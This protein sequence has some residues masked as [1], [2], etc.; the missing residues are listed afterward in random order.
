MSRRWSVAGVAW[1]IAVVG[2]VLQGIVGSWLAAVLWLVVMGG[3]GALFSPLAFPRAESA[4]QAEQLSAT[5][6][7]PIIYW[8]P[9]C[10]FC[11]RLRL[12]LGARGRRAHWVDIW[13]DPDGAAAVRA[14]AGGNE[15]VPTLIDGAESFVNPD[16]SWV[17]WRLAV[18]A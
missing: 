7:R 17:R 11:L 8:R 3:F 4:A 10:P 5:D 1:A 13:R 6:G 9:G 15:T 18:N 12:R 2:S 16:P 14:V